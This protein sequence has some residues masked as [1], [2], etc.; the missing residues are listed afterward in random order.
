[1]D[2]RK[3]EQAIGFQFTDTDWLQQA[4]THRSY[5]SRNNERLEFIGD[6]I[7]NYTVAR[8][9]YD[10]FPQLLEGDLSRLRAN[11]VNQ[12]TLAEL[13]YSLSLGGYL[14]LGEGERKSGGFNRP[15]IL[16]DAMEAIFAAVSFDAD[17]CQAEQV[18]QRLYTQ[19][20]AEINPKK[21][22]K[23]AKTQLQEIIQA[24]RL[25]L[26]KYLI[27]QQ[28]GE[29]HDQMFKVSCELPDLCLIAYGEGGSRRAAEQV[30][31]ASIL[32]PLQNH[33][34]KKLKSK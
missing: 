21:Q 32:Q 31:A 22:F 30:A 27:L 15:S 17:F 8:M 25:S 4:L 23:D 12:G 19:R 18:I 10:R 26:P 11:L 9:L 24:H 7:L 5:S 1:M 14:L 13:A 3:L 2:I 34:K 28:Q 29:A 33:L 20:I 16:A 6:S